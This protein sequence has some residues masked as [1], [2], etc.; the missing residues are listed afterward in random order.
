MKVQSS[1]K[2]VTFDF[3][4]RATAKPLINR[5]TGALMLG[6]SESK[7]WALPASR[8]D[9]FL[10]VNGQ[11]ITADPARS[12]TWYDRQWGTG[13]FTNWTWFGLHIPQTG[14]IF[15]N[16]NG[17]QRVCNV[18]WT[19]DLSRTWYSSAANQT[20]PLAWT[21]QIPDYDATFKIAS[22]T[23]NQLNLGSSGTDT[24]AYNGFVTFS[25][26]FEET[27]IEGFGIVEVWCT[28][29]MP[30]GEEPQTNNKTILEPQLQVLCW[31]A[32]IFS[33]AT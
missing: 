30:E 18:I 17:S 9:G 19:P 32:I 4:F 14:Y 29:K 1:H 22:V 20:Y 24:P 23:K 26:Q 10:I 15:R 16:T 27:K 28:C 8:I 25:G 33:T 31:I 6:A 12:L 5:C 7:Q 3:T 2:N 21:A 11:H 13:G